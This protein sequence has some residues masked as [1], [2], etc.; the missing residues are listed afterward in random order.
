[1]IISGDTFYGK[2]GF[3]PIDK[4]DKKRYNKTKLK[5]VEITLHDFNFDKYLDR[6][7][8]KNNKIIT[9]NSV[10]KIKDNIK[11][12]NDMKIGKLFE[13]LSNKETFNENCVLIN[14]LMNK[15][16]EKIK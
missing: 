7:F 9:K 5:L 8:N 3:V 12:N 16:F 1:M 14:Y 13:I 15:I 4:D 11:K 2:H 10:E 6:F